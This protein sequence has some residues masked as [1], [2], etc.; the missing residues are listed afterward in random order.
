MAKETHK[1]ESRSGR[2]VAEIMPGGTCVYSRAGTPSAASFSHPA[3]P[4]EDSGRAMRMVG[5]GQP[6]GTLKILGL[7][8]LM[9]S[10][11]ALR[12]LAIGSRLY[13][14]GPKVSRVL[15]IG[16]H[17]TNL[18]DERKP[19]LATLSGCPGLQAR[20]CTKPLRLSA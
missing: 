8:L 1:V 5:L 2:K 15:R 4:R 19:G 14:L 6:Y 11:T 13:P 16:V 18:G 7:L 3:G 12:L 9:W 10:R 20:L 17:G